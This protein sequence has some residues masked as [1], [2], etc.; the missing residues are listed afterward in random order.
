MSRILS[1]KSPLFFLLGLL[2][3]LIFVPCEAAEGGDVAVIVNPKNPATNISLADLRKMFRGA[4]HS[5]AGGIPVKLF[6]RAPG[7]HERIVLLR[8]VGMSESEYAQYWTAQVFRGEADS[9]PL[10][11]SSF[12]MALEAAK[13]FPG[14][15]AFVDARDIK[16]GMYVKVIKV[17]GHMPGDEGYPLH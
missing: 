8:L 5:W 4:K 9:E 17:D 6:V 12:G 11:L 16:P 1:R 3:S 15:I 10:S 14:A 7:S 2:A 13:A